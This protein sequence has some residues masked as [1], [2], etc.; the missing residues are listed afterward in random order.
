MKFY[1][2]FFLIIYT[3]TSGYI[4]SQCKQE[5]IN[6][7]NGNYFGCVNYEGEKD[8]EGTLTL[9]LDSQTQIKQGFFENDDFVRGKLLINFLEGDIKTIHYQNYQTDLIE[10]ESYEWNNGDKKNTYYSDGKKV[11]EI[12]T[13]GPGESKGLVIE[14]FFEKNKTKIIRNIDNNRVPTDIIGDKEYSDISLSERDN[15]YRINVGFPTINGEVMNVP[16]QFDSGATS[17]FIGNRLYKDLLSNCEIED[18]NVKS[19]SGGVGSEFE[20]KYVKIKEILIGDY[21]VKN[22]VAVVPLREDINDL[23]IGIGFL[24]KFKEVLWSL[25]SN[26]MRFYK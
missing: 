21:L 26:L 5:T 23:L 17:F 8:G 25:N 18:M 14:K 22:V 7:D 4:F 2:E 24:K 16:I 11:K 3:L 15:Q 13:Y 6:Y 10:F 20:T 12:S 1:R 9:K 19:V